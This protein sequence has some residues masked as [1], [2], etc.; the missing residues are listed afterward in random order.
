MG[1]L[2]D[3][4]IEI[5][6]LASVKMTLDEEYLNLSIKC[7]EQEKQRL[8][9][10]KQAPYIALI[11]DL[12]RYRDREPSLFLNSAVLYDIL[13][14]H[15]HYWMNLEDVIK[16]FEPKKDI[17]EAIRK[18]LKFDAGKEINEAMEIIK[19]MRDNIQ[20]AKDYMADIK[21]ID[22]SRQRIENTT[23]HDKVVN[24]LSDIEQYETTIMFQN[25][26]I[27]LLREKKKQINDFMLI[28]NE[29]E[30]KIIQSYLNDT[31]YYSSYSDV[32]KI[33]CDHLDFWER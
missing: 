2:K 7:L 30:K 15:F 28:L 20:K 17:A 5:Q 19:T 16:H 23:Y 6:A 22:Y 14:Y 18:N 11:A 13:R 26:R 27:E 1:K 4:M 29:D 21:A 31:D 9:S 25:R 3:D 12:K 33:I 32:K 8:E 24:A 10:D